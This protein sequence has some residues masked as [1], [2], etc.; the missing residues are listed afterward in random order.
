MVGRQLVSIWPAGIVNRIRRG[1]IFGHTF[2]PGVSGFTSS[3]QLNWD[4]IG[5]PLVFSVFPVVER[6]EKPQ[7]E[8]KKSVQIFKDETR[9]R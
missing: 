4:F 2:C 5:L 8:L 7:L 3:S 6:K 1:I 9:G